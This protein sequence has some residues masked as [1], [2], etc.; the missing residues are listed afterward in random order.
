MASGWFSSSQL[1]TLSV[2]PHLSFN[3]SVLQCYPQLTSQ[4]RPM[5][6][7]RNLGDFPV[8]LVDLPVTAQPHE[9]PRGTILRCRTRSLSVPTGLG[10][11]QQISM[12]IAETEDNS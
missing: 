3:F 10:I 4:Y 8:V 6:S 1:Q 9:A 2:K 7:L 5:I 12:E 11:C